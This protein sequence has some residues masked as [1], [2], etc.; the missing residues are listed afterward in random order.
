[1]HDMIIDHVGVTTIETVPLR[2]SIFSERRVHGDT[3]DSNSHPAVCVRHFDQMAGWPDA[4][5]CL[6]RL[7][8]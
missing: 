5:I 7:L 8:Q 6:A 3:G 1:M 2:P 4:I